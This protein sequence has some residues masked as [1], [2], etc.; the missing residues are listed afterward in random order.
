MTE[1][2]GV[3]LALVSM[4]TMLFFQHIILKKEG[5]TRVYGYAALFLSILFF[6]LGIFWYLRPQLCTSSLWAIFGS[7]STVVVILIASV[8]SKHWKITQK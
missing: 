4:S 7:I 3:F 2:D 8:L 6:V 5:D 1:L